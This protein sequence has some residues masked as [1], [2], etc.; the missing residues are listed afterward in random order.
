M[1]PSALVLV[2]VLLFTLGACVSGAASEPSQTVEPFGPSLAPTPTPTPRPTPA[3]TPVRTI[4]PTPIPTPGI[5]A[6]AACKTV[7]GDFMDELADLDADVTIGITR[8]DYADAVTSALKAYKRIDL[9]SLSTQPT[10]LSEVAVPGEKAL[11][12][13][14]SASSSWTKCWDAWTTQKKFDACFDKYVQLHWS[15]A[16]AGEADARNGMIALTA[17]G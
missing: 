13:Y 1:K 10:C 12:E 4:A 8:A 15:K 17:A 14:I 9:A 2:P 11:N 3:P 6:Y 7:L 5:T 16:D